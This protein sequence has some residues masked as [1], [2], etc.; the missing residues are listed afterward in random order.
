[1][2]RYLPSSSPV[3]FAKIQIVGKVEEYPAKDTCWNMDFVGGG[4]FRR[5]CPLKTGQTRLASSCSQ[6]SVA[7][8]TVSKDNGE[9]KKLRVGLGTAEEIG[10]RSAFEH[11]GAK[12]PRV[13]QKADLVEVLSAQWLRI[14]A[15]Q[16]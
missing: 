11:S 6:S 1:M 14:K 13:Q 5:L 16:P 8:C 10:G 3:G 7:S 4:N 15:L 9:F 2:L 12:K